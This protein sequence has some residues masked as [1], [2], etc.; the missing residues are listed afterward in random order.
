MEHIFDI[1][2]IIAILCAALIYLY[3]IF[4]KSRKNCGSICSGCSGSCQKKIK[5]FGKQQNITFHKLHK[6]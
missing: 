6:S 5:Q 4:Q 2:V 3:K 1:I